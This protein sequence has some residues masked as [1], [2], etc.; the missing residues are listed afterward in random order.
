MQCRTR[1][2][3]IQACQYSLFSQKDI[4]TAEK[5]DCESGTK[6]MSLYRLHRLYTSAGVEC[7]VRT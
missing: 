5:I 6:G 2:A 1:A 7:F 4:S 3:I